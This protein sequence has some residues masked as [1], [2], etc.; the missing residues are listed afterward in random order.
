MTRFLLSAREL[1]PID[2]DWGKLIRVYS[3]GLRAAA[4]ARAR[5]QPIQD[6]GQGT[7]GASAIDGQCAEH[8]DDGGDDPRL[9][10]HASPT[11]QG[12]LGSRQVRAD[13]DEAHESIEVP[14]DD[15]SGRCVRRL[16]ENIL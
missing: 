10:F 14:V 2:P 9:N 12:V 8:D 1:R 7:V 6:G 15:A 4:R 16:L 5:S 13:R 11:S 3:Q